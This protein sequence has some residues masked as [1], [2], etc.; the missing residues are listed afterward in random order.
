MHVSRH[1]QSAVASGSPLESLNEQQEEGYARKRRSCTSVLNHCSTVMHM[2]H[3]MCGFL[4]GS[5]GTWEGKML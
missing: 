1:F 5:R 4:L 3:F 2:F